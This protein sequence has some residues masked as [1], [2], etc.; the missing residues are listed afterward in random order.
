[1]AFDEDRSLFFDT[2]DGFAVL[3]TFKGEPISVIVDDDF[4]AVPGEEVDIASSR[5][6][7]HCQSTDVATATEGDALTIEEGDRAGNYTI[8][9]PIRP[10]GTGFTVLA[11]EAQ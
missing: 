10:D 11:L 3:A 2:D 6:T 8:I 9:P 7:V 4:Y 5:L 1:M